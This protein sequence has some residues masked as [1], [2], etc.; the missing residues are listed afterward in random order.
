M[1]RGSRRFSIAT[2]KLVVKCESTTQR[3]M[4]G[5]GDG[6]RNLRS[7][8]RVAEDRDTPTKARTRINLNM[9]LS[10]PYNGEQAVEKYRRQG[11]F[12]M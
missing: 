8:G 1:G 4:G 9:A 2:E 11:H 10:H 7:D 6:A 12:R 3:W 5:T